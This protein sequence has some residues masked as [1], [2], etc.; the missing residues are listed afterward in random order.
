M[1][2]L[3]IVA[4]LSLPVGALA[5]INPS[6]Q[7]LQVFDRY[8]AI[9][10]FTITSSDDQAR[11]ATLSVSECL[12]GTF[13]AKSVTVEA[14]DEKLA[15]FFSSLITK[16]AALVAF[17]GK[18]IGKRQVNEILFYTGGG[19]WEKGEL[20]DKDDL[21]R[22]LWTEDTGEAY[23]GCFNGRVDRLLEMVKDQKRE[24]FYFPDKPFLRFKPDVV[25]GKLPGPSR[26]V[27][28]YD[29]NGD[30]ALDVYACSLAG[31][32]AYVQVGPRQFEDRTDALG[33]AGVCSPS[34]SFADINGDGFPD[35]LAGGTLYL[36]D[37]K[38]KFAKTRLLPVIGN[39]SLKIAMFADVNGDGYPDVLVSMV[40]GGLHLYLNSGKEPFSFRDASE[41]A[42]L[43]TAGAYQDSTGFVCWGD[44]NQDHRIDFYYSAKRGVLLTQ[45]EDGRFGPVKTFAGYDFA[46]SAGEEGAAGAGCFASL[47]RTDRND[48][49]T[50]AEGGIILLGNENGKISDLTSEG[51][52]LSEQTPAMMAVIAE[53]LNADGTLDLYTLTRN[54]VA[55]IFH[56]NRGYGSFMADHKYDR[57]IYHGPGHLQGAWGVAAGDIDGDGANDL[58]LG[59][60]DGTVSLLIN[61]SLSLRV[62]TENPL[63][64]DQI[65]QHARYLRVQVK[66]RTGVLGAEI[67]V[68]DAAKRIVARRTIGTNVATGCRGPDAST[69]AV[70]WPGSHHLHVRFSNGTEKTQDVDLSQAVHTKLVISND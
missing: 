52:E 20:V 31:D 7:P 41:E 40:G 12:K 66:G 24:R 60:H 48:I 44:W 6:L 8:D 25:V 36:A 2:K 34:V 11:T 70:L 1:F 45:D 35:L 69:I 5:L 57:D 22:W 37:G 68:T 17:I 63:Y 10:L 67:T 27:A 59:G 49:V 65:R 13:P 39:A 26:G 51:N 55:N 19:H 50:T 21:S 3:L 33:L 4:A 64:H 56:D 46:S 28:L 18:R 23:F 42:G 43:R 9:V 14:K 38:G 61:D 54:Q 15:Q 32:R 53:D 47:W 29:W 30:G 58:L 62:P 16:D